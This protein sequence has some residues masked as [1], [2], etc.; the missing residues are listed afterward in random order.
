MKII[1]PQQA[2]EKIAALI[3][4]IKKRF[5]AYPLTEADRTIIAFQLEIMQRANDRLVK[6]AT[7]G[8]LGA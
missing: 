2:H 8:E 4:D 7:T 1:A 6:K 3:N 5:E